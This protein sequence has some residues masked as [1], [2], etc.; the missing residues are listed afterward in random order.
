MIGSKNNPQITMKKKTLLFILC[1]QLGAMNIH[2]QNA[3]FL[4]GATEKKLFVNNRILAKVNDKPI[5]VLDVMKKMDLLFYRQYPQYAGSTEARFK[6]Y[7]MYWKNAL[8]ECIDKELI[9]ADAQEAKMEVSPGDIRQE[10]EE[11]FGPNIIANLDTSGLTYD[12]ALQLIK[13]DMIMKRMMGGRVNAVAIRM[14]TP[15]AVQTA[16]EEYAKNSVKSDEWGYQVIS[17]RG[18]DQKESA[19]IADLAYTLLI[20]KN[21]TL[22][23][24]VEKIN[25]DKPIN[26][27][28]TIKISEKFRHSSKDVSKEYGEILSSLEVGRFSKPTSQVSR[29]DNS[30]VYR[31]FYLTDM[32]SGNTKSFEEIENKLRDKLIEIMV[33]KETE[34]YIAKLRKHHNVNEELLKEMVPEDFEPFSMK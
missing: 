13:D 6:F 12:E 22:D 33:G 28:T 8:Q 7:S 1:L 15:Q 26:E 11:L 24:L 23:T 14:V 34:K 10:M 25:A 32:Y 19:E 21:T 3:P 18:D 4:F 20:A 31:I 16:Y 9:I 30:T 29:A 17:I 5:S 2:A 27:K